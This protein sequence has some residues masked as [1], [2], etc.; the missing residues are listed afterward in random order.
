MK[1]SNFA[2]SG[3]SSADSISQFS[4][5]S[6]S[7]RP[8]QRRRGGRRAARARKSDNDAD[9]VDSVCTSI[10]GCGSGSISGSERKVLRQPEARQSAVVDS[11]FES[12]TDRNDKVE[13]WLSSTHGDQVL[14][15]SNDQYVT[16]I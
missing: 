13:Q 3:Y 16:V 8:A 11:E 5:S 12:K 15:Y 4:T 10:S 6:T 1:K 2:S 9:T 7:T 14:Y